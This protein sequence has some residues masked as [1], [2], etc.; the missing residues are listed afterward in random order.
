MKK[1]SGFYADSLEMLLDTMCNVL[2]GIVFITLALA[3]LTRASPNLPPDYY[4]KQGAQ[5]TNALAAAASSN[6]WVEAELEH[7][8]QRLQDPRPGSSTN[9]MSLPHETTTTKTP[10]QVIVRYGRIYP[11]YSY[12]ASARDG[13]GQ[14]AQTVEWRQAPGPSLV[15]EPRPGQGQD[16][17]SGVESMVSAFQSVAKTNY[18]F[19][20]WVYEDSFAAFD[21]A[22]ETAASLGF[23]YGW[24][25]VA[26]NT[27]IMTKPGGGGEIIP[28]QN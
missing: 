19:V 6:A 16:P 8:L 9:H 28:P 24:N 7:T 12:S 18:Q 5:L 26:S 10:W 23:Q 17:E 13:K 2:G 27:I 14:N 4:E 3:V 25:P 1:A 11:L 20:F 21:R 22:K 15:V